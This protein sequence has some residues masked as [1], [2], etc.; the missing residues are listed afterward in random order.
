MLNFD[1]KPKNA[2]SNKKK[3]AYVSFIAGALPNYQFKIN[4]KG[5]KN[6]KRV[7]SSTLTYG[8][9]FMDESWYYN[10][11]T[12]CILLFL[13]NVAYQFAAYFSGLL[14]SEFYLVLLS[15]DKSGYFKLLIKSVFIVLICAF[16]LALN[17][18]LSGSIQA[19]ART[20]LT[21][22]TQENYIKKNVLNTLNFQKKI[23]N[24]DQR[25][26][27][28]IDKLSASFMN[29]ITKTI[30]SPAVII[31]YSIRT[32]LITGYYGPLSIYLY[33]II[34]SVFSILLVPIVAS[35]I[36]NLEKAEGFFRNQHVKIRDSAEEISFMGG[37]DNANK[38]VNKYM[39]ALYFY[40]KTVVIFTFP[41]YSPLSYAIIGIAVFAGFYDD[42]N[43]SEQANIISKSSFMSMYL[44]FSF[45]QVLETASEFAKLVGYSVRITQLWDEL[46][47]INLAVNTGYIK[48]S[49]DNII[50]MNNLEIATPAGTTL[51]S[52]LTLKIETGQ[53]LLI[54]G[55]NGCGKTSIIRALVGIWKPTEGNVY[56]PFKNGVPDLYILPQQN[57][58][59]NGSLAD[60]ITYPER[61]SNIAMS[62]DFNN[63]MVK[64][65]QTVG[66]SH[67]LKPEFF[68]KIVTDDQVYSYETEYDDES[69]FNVKYSFTTW[70]NILSPGE[71]QKLSLAR[72]FYRAPRYAIL[73]ESTSSLDIKSEETI[74]TELIKMNVT[75]I[76]ISHRKSLEKFHRSILNIEQHGR[77]SID[78][79]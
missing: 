56:L 60:Q 5:L 33:F 53:N 39:K 61:L 18:F 29:V 14:S 71:Q 65:I 1:N 36:Y 19:K 70:Q 78:S 75:L 35:K 63:K 26:T 7:V 11:K 50:E 51:I 68:A 44:I 62:N 40:Q 32:W 9:A 52:N 59:V 17:N 21:M 72:I 22:Y 2:L 4:F 15:A 48:K 20:I 41:I 3:V 66:L 6:F 45:T 10:I 43:P 69:T 28:D 79:N 49:P 77:F 54:T 34:G 46:E 67:L 76:S 58:L 25:I 30:I 13:G 16:L 38:E 37:E 57:M 27:Q 64:I 74:Y 31:Y 24:P 47:K 55:P 8:K 73:D 42:K 12:L 23:D